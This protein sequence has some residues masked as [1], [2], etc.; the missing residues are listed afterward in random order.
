MILK[1]AYQ[2]PTFFAR[3]GTCSNWLGTLEK[4]SRRKQLDLGYYKTQST[5]KE[6]FKLE[7]AILPRK[8]K[9]SEKW[10]ECWSSA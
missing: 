5:E 1:Q 7:G 9:T 6:T 10:S 4:D 2:N 8:R 3:I